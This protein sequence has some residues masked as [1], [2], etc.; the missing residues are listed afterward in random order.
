[1][2]QARHLW[3]Q[4]TGEGD[5]E[6]GALGEGRAR[7]ERRNLKIYGIT[8][9]DRVGGVGLRTRFSLVGIQAY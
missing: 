3:P 7:V 5:G 8:C 6:T 2:V 9:R 4:T 1:M